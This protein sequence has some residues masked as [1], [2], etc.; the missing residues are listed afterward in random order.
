MTSDQHLSGTDR[1]QEVAQQYHLGDDH[2]VV[3]VQ[4]DEPCIPPAVINQVAHNLSSCSTAAA[5]T[6][7]EKI[8]DTSTFVNP[9]AVK[10]VVDHAQMAL[11]FSRA[12]VP[13]PRNAAQNSSLNDI[14]LETVSSVFQRHIGIYAYRVSLLHDFVHWPVSPLESI[15]CLEQL[16]ILHHARK[17]HVDI[18]CEPVPAGVDTQQDLDRVRGRF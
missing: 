17:I 13:F 18:A 8:T 3:N 9:N 5:A 2:I 14:S 11:Y 16:R 15:E 12:A 6:L 1:I 10:V 7:A 4:G